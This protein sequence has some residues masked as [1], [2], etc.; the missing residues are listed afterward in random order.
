M[1]TG[2][3]VAS[4]YCVSDWPELTLS[5]KETRRCRMKIYRRKRDVDDSNDKLPKVVTRY[6]TALLFVAAAFGVR[7]LLNPVLGE[8]NRFVLF[9]PA[10]M[11]AA[12]FGGVGPSLLATGVS[13]LLANY[14]SVSPTGRW[15][16]TD[17]RD[18]SA[19]AVYVFVALA[20]A[21]MTNRHRKEQR[22]SLRKT[23]ALEKENN[24]RREAEIRLAEREERLR[25]IFENARHVAIISFDLNGDIE[26]WNPGAETI[27]GYRKDEAVGKSGAILFAAVDEFRAEL[28]RAKSEGCTREERPFIR[29]DGSLVVVSCTMC[30]KLT[31]AGKLI[32]YLKMARDITEQ[33]EVQEKLRQ[34]EQRFRKLYEFAPMGVAQV[35]P[36]GRFIEANPKYCEIVGYSVEELRSKTFYDITLPEDLAND[37]E[38]FEKSI[39]GEIPFYR[40][41]KRYIR[42]DGTIIWVRITSSFLRDSA[43]NPITTISIVED[44]TERKEADQRTRKSEER[45]RLTTESANIGV[46]HW[47]VNTGKMEGSAIFAE[48]FD[49][50]QFVA[51]NF[52]VCLARI[53]SGDQKRILDLLQRC[54]NEGIPAEAEYRVVWHDGTVRWLWGKAHPIREPDGRIAEVTG[55]TMDITERKNSENTLRKRFQLLNLAQVFVRDLNDKILNWYGGA[56]NLYG[57]PPEEAIGKNAQELLRTEF[58]EPISKINEKLFHT[59]EW[60]GE[61]VHRS[62]DGRRIVVASHWALHTDHEKRP[63]A[64]L[65]SNNDITQLKNAEQETRHAYELIQTIADNTSSAIFMI[66]AE[67]YPTFMNRAAEEITGFKLNELKGKKLHDSIHY[68]HPNGSPY[69]F[70]NCP[71]CRTLTNAQPLRHHEDVFY[72]KDGTRFP[73]ECAASPI[74][75]NGKV[76]SV[77]IEFRDITVRKQT[78]WELLKTREELAEYAQELEQRVSDRTAALERSVKEMETLLYSIAHDLRAPLRAMRGFSIALEDDFAGVLGPEGHDYCKRIKN[79]AERMDQLITDLL[80]FGRLSHIELPSQQVDLIAEIQKVL[81]RVEAE[82]AKRQAEITIAKPLPRVCADAPVLDQV[83]ENLISNALKFVPAERPPKIRIYADRHD[84][85][86]RL[87]VEDN[88]IGI[89]PQFQTRIFGPFQRLHDDRLYPGTGIG[90]AIVQKAVEKMGGS[91]GVESKLGEGSKFW[92]ELPEQG[93]CVNS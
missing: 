73:V 60:E 74:T 9:V 10:V 76:A 55:I 63:I 85:R 67:G 39:S 18:I 29:K 32:G 47:D 8:Q 17:W 81:E 46:W 15:S 83:L 51:N 62:K 3:L 79:G 21:T 33:A 41:E 4:P 93:H 61:L 90:L 86:V 45:L 14:F 2:L 64:I 19:G 68:K 78:E 69:A 50:P 80:A 48:Q 71:I 30:A 91:V 72:R 84:D 24:A 77:V 12:W 65:E 23:I 66:N 27:F 89:E 88:G 37:R 5:L 44:V 20:V 28:E 25:L 82:A 22:R 59:G 52:D 75:E 6:G 43:G 58:P 57:W 40:T 11:L 7:F 16:F 70:S 92:I 13:L 42:K 26:D 1:N 35:L 54:R 31:K 87:W 53:H 38:Q 56:K 36:S 34:S 49:L